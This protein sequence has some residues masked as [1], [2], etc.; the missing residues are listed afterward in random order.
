[1]LTITAAICTYKRSSQAMQ[2]IRSLLDQTLARA[3]YRILVVETPPSDGRLTSYV[4]EFPDGAVEACVI[5]EPVLGVSHARNT[6]LR[7]CTTD[8]IAFLDDDALASP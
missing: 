5:T 1:M 7:S 6:A 4:A 2:A 8:L 3:R